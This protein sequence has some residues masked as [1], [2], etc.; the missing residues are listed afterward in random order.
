MNKNYFADCGSF[1]EAKK[2][3]RELMMEHHPDHGGNEETCK[4]II[5]DFEAFSMG[6]INTA[7]DDFE[8][9]KGYRP[10]SA[11]EMFAEILATVCRFNMTVEIIGFWIYAREG[12]YEYKAQLAELGFWFSR[13]WKAWIFSGRKKGAKR[14]TRMSQDQVRASHGSEILR[15]REEGEERSADGFELRA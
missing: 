11:A 10:N 3:Y 1:P 8:K 2:L 9:E 5:N 7:F 6:Y 14:A 4:Q 15:E 12:S 13:K